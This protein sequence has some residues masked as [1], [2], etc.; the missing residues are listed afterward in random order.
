MRRYALRQLN[1][2]DGV[3][4]V[5]ESGQARAF[6]ANGVLWRMQVQ[7][8]RPEHTWRSD[9][10]RPVRQYFSWGL[11]S[12][13]RGMQRVTANPIL[14]IGAMQ[15]AADDLAAALPE[16][17]EALPFALV[18]RFEY[19][20]CDHRGRPVALIASTADADFASGSPAPAWCATTHAEHGFVS[21]ALLAAGEPTH[22]GFSPRAHAQR[23][24]SAVRHQAQDRCWIERL[25]DGSGRRLRDGAGLSADALPLLGLRT[26]WNDPLLGR[27]AA[28]YHEW[29]APLLLTL[30]DLDRDTRARLE[31]AAI[32]RPTLV[33]DL[34][35]L[36]P[37]IVDVDIITRA[38]VEARLRRAH[39]SSTAD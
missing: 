16:Q 19:W 36:Y 11:W 14:D 20:A 32:K 25:D 13:E 17:L 1:P 2:F 30:P 9:D 28:D 3:L 31:R 37:E 7:A 22:D 38:R 8:E 35:R 24:E 5:V 12:A 27:L 6:T 26:D 15:Q 10:H 33:A 29:L 21:P 18:D 34:F 39:A 4:Q 23:L